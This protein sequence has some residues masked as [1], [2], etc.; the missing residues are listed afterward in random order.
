MSCTEKAN[1]ELYREGL[2]CAVQKRL[3][4]GWAEKGNSLIY[5]ES[6][7][8]IVQRRQSLWF[9]EEDIRRKL[10]VC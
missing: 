8:C 9:K 6:I 7:Q 2:Q 4:A 10:A 3:A 1:S 5:R